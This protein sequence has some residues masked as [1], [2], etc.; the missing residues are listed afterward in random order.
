MDK[1]PNSSGKSKCD[2]S[3]IEDSM[4]G[5][6]INLIEKVFVAPGLAKRRASEDRLETMI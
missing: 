2:A 4:C 6:S 5:Y 3:S 1:Y